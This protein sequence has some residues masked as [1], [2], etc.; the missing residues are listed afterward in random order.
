MS[1]QTPSKQQ[2]YTPAKSCTKSFG[3]PGRAGVALLFAA[4]CVMDQ[5]SSN[6]V[7]AFTSSSVPSF[8]RS[9]KSQRLTSSVKKMQQGAHDYDGEED[10]PGPFFF[11]GEPSVDDTSVQRLETI[12]QKPVPS[13]PLAT[14]TAP[15]AQISDDVSMDMMSDDYA[16]ED[17]DPEQPFFFSRDSSVD[18][19]LVRL[20]EIFENETG[21]TADNEK[22]SD[23]W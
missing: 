18:E 19:R 13:S 7:N 21:T 8:A 9:R 23:S 5:S 2:S 14:A 10:M 16:F 17:L 6:H 4:G 20:K 15:L 12:F 22:A 11:S 3:T 1:F